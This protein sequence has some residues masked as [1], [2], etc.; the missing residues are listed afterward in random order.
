MSYWPGP[1]LEQFVK[2]LHGDRSKIL[3]QKALEHYEPKRKEIERKLDNYDG[4]I[5]GAWNEYLASHFWEAGIVF[6]EG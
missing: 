2:S 1:T 5:H 6:Y 4:T 3:F